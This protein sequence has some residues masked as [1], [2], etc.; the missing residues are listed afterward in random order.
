M[1]SI[2]YTLDQYWSETFGDSSSDFNRKNIELITQ[3]SDMTAQTVHKNELFDKVVKMLNVLSILLNSKLFF[4]EVL[5]QGDLGQHLMR[6]TFKPE[7]ELQ[8]IS[9]DQTHLLR[10]LASQALKKLIQHYSGTESKQ[11]CLNKRL[12]INGSVSQV[13]GETS[14]SKRSTSTKG[15]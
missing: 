15:E 9:Q 3:K 6:F 1:S 13:G 5:D 2:R 7:N 14:S 11:E 4:T 10:L 12:L 8:P